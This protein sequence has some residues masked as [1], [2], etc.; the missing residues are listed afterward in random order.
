MSIKEPL[1]AQAQSTKLEGAGA[2]LR[3]KLT[4]YCEYETDWALALSDTDKTNHNDYRFYFKLK[5]V[6]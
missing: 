3:G 1:P 5:A 6:F 4:K 2:G